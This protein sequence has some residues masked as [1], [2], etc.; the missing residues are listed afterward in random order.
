VVTAEVNQ[1]VL[2]PLF[3]DRLLFIAHGYVIAG[4]DLSRI[5][6]EDMWLDQGVLHVRLPA[7]EVLVATLDNE[8]S[9]VYDRETGVF[10]HGE[11]DLET[12]ARQVAEDEI[13]K[14]ALADG[15]LDQAQVNANIF[16][17]RFF[18][19]LGYETVYFE[20]PSP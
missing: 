9:Y 17:E 2:D 16:L 7:A 20:D 11:M 4:V 3:G 12:L 5:D 13:L 10:S 14:A 1:G 15:I 19:N 6:P 8:K 18:Q